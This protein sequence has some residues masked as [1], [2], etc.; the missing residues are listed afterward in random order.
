[1]RLPC[2]APSPMAFHKSRYLWATTVGR[3]TPL[4]LRVAIACI[5]KRIRLMTTA[6][7][8][9][10]IPGDVAIAAFTKTVA[11]KRLNG[12]CSVWCGTTTCQVQ[13]R[14]VRGSHSC[15]GRAASIS[16]A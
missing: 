4:Y 16:G 8:T 3:T 2:C 5:T 15:A 7:W 10:C 1:M 6:M 14:P 12:T 11:C 9:C 13:K